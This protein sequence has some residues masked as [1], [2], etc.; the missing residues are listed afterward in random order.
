MQCRRGRGGGEPYQAPECRSL[1]DLRATPRRD[2][3][4]KT[5]ASSDLSGEWWCLTSPTPR[6]VTDGQCL[7]RLG[8]DQA[9]PRAPPAAADNRGG[10]PRGGARM[11]GTETR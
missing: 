9:G 6:E 11:A 1:K 7:T 8:A 2:K 5:S 3:A 4:Y 10:L